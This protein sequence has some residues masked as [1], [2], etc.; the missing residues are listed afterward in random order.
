[1]F[2]SA[3]AVSARPQPKPFSIKGHYS[4][5]VMPASLDL[6]SDGF[7]AAV[8]T[9]A[10]ESS[11]GKFTAQAVVDTALSSPGV[12][13]SGNQGFVLKGGPGS[14]G[15]VFRFESGE[16]LAA[17]I[18]SAEQCVDGITLTAF[19]SA[20]LEITGGS[21]RFSHASGELAVTATATALAVDSKGLAFSMTTGSFSGKLTTE[22]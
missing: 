20:Q 22:N 18:V 6:D 16:L 14:G 8:A 12:C 1:V 21:G 3:G 15:I 10:G 5:S 7:P 13:P 2:V 11:L 19:I 9:L 17:Q 4:G